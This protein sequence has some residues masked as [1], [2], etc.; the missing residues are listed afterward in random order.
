MKTFGW[1]LVLGMMSVSGC[2]TT[3]ALTPKGQSVEIVQQ[4]PTTSCSNLGPVVGKGGGSFG[5]AWISDEDL[6]RYAYNDLRNKAG[7]MGAT[8]VVAGAHQMGH[9]S[10][11]NGG[12]TSTATLSG[13]AYACR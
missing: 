12:A 13:I 1:W 4:P 7:L 3:A 9:T 2:V 5:G 11:A 6:I 10:G 8:H